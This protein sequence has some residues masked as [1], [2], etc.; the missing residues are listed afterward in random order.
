LLR[1]P[2]LKM[3]ADFDCKISEIEIEKKKNDWK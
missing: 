3:P 1:H 2:W